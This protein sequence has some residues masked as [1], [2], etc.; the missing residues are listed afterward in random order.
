MSFLQILYNVEDYNGNGGL[1]SSYINGQGVSSIETATQ[2][3]DGKWKIDIFQ[4]LSAE[5]GINS[6]TKLGVQAP[7]GTQFYINDQVQKA[8]GGSSSLG[9][10]IMVGRTGIYELNEGAE[11]RSLQFKEP[12][13]YILDVDSSRRMMEEGMSIMDQAKDSFINEI[14]GL[15]LTE[16][17]ALNSTTQSNY[18]KEYQEAHESYV[19]AYELGRSKYIQGQAGIYIENEVSQNDLRNIIIDIIYPDIG[20]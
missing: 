13:S 11:I 19:K 2:S 4:D 6:I 12:Y 18:R 16:G 9:Y 17:T 5:L 15:Q 8:D 14:N 1:I 7:P 10:S 20:G 3:P